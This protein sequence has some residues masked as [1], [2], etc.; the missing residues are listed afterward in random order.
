[1]KSCMTEFVSGTNSHKV[2]KNL[3]IQGTDLTRSK[4]I[5]IAGTH[6]ATQAQLKLMTETDELQSLLC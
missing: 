5:D 3:I 4:A 1:M 6:E 2:Q